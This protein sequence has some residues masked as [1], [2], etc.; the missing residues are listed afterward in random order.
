MNAP[1]FSSAFDREYR[2]LRKYLPRTTIERMIRERRDA[3]DRGGHAR[4]KF[5]LGVANKQQ[6]S[7]VPP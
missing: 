7:P 6:F 3:G 1:F 5:E 4:R 2:K